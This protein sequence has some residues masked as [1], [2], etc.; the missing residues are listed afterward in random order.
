MVV[1]WRKQ[2]NMGSF[3]QKNYYLKKGQI[4]PRCTRRGQF[5]N[6]FHNNI[7]NTIYQYTYN[8]N[9]QYP[10]VRFIVALFANSVQ[11]N[12]EIDQIDIIIAVLNSGLYMEQTE[13]L[14]KE[15]D[16][17]KVSKLK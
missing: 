9:I 17:A 16:N 5:P 12:Y 10:I 7:I 6:N 2:F 1:T 14:T 15:E 8:I 3:N 13:N 4:K 11:L